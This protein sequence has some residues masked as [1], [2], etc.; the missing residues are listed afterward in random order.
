M[1]HMREQR[2]VW[3]LILLTSSVCFCPHDPKKKTKY[4]ELAQTQPHLQLLVLI[5]MC[6]WLFIVSELLASLT[7]LL[8]PVSSCYRFYGI[9]Q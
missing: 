5:L 2:G 9:Q 8:L 7:D 6:S 1:T 3:R 4:L